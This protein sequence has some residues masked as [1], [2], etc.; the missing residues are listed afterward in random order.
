MRRS[1]DQLRVIVSSLNP[2]KDASVN[3]FTIDLNEH[4]NL[5]AENVSQMLG[6]VADDRPWQL[7]VTSGGIAYM[8]EK[9]GKDDIEG[10]AFR[11]ETLDAGNGYV[12]LQAAKDKLW[13]GTVLLQLQK[14][15]PS[16]R[17]SYIDY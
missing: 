10:L 11:C 7:R 8:S 16:P 5:T 15:W 1:P 3:S 2:S 12:G 13:V 9:V 17:S 6:S 4:K 14:N